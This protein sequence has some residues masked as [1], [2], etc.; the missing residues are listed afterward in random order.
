MTNEF[1]HRTGEDWLNA[2]REAV[3]NDDKTAAL[4]AL[5]NLGSAMVNFKDVGATHVIVPAAEH[6]TEEMVDAS[7]SLLLYTDTFSSHDA[8][9]IR[10]L[11]SRRGWIARHLP[12]WFREY[13]G[14]LTKAARAILTYHL[15]TMAAL[16]PPKEEE[17]HFPEPR[18]VKPRPG[19]QRLW[20]TL[21]D[22]DTQKTTTMGWAYETSIFSNKTEVLDI[23]INR[24]QLPDD[25]KQFFRKQA[26]DIGAQVEKGEDNLYRLGNH[27]TRLGLKSE[28]VQRITF[29][30]DDGVGRYKEEHQ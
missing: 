13:E 1:K 10:E 26:I 28:F 15:A 14:H 24:H 16:D 3:L 6:M 17:K 30:L 19:E 11:L 20:I 9:Y 8:G 29:E 7:R 23:Q 18:R 27:K 22:T 25:W 4:M 12:E 5:D 2:I 21:T